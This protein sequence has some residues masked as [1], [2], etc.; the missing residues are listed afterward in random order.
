MENNITDLLETLASKLGTTVE[1]LYGVLV[2]Q[3]KIDMAIGII[4]EVVLAALL[5]GAYIGW[6]YLIPYC[7]GKE[8]P[9]EIQF[10]AIFLGLSTLGLL[11]GFVV[12]LMELISTVAKGIYNPEASAIEKITGYINK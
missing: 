10:C 8:W 7:V 3:A 11:I 5:V 4:Q 12:C 6:E 9:A 1:R 2:K